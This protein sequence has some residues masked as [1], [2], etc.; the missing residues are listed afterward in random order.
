MAFFA[1]SVMCRRLREI[2]PP[3]QLKRYAS[4]SH[5]GAQHARA[6]SG[7]GESFERSFEVGEPAVVI[8]MIGLDVGDDDRV[9]TDLEKGAVA[10]VGFD[11]EQ[12]TAVPYRTR[13]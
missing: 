11:D 2:A 1:S 12:L 10:L 5:L 13:P 7:A 6:G 8:E 4:S 9:G 3:R